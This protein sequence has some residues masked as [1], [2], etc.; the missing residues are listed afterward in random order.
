[1]AT[2][3]RRLILG[4]LSIALLISSIWL[5]SELSF[6]VKSNPPFYFNLI[7]AI[8]FSFNIA[9]LFAWF[10]FR[11]LGGI[12]VT[13]LS[14]LAVLW[15]DLRTGLYGYSLFTLS[16]FIAIFLGYASFRI[17]NRIDS[18]YTLKLEKLD[19]QSNVLSNKIAEQKRMIISLEEK[20]NR[21]STLKEI[22]ES[23]STQL[24]L[25]DVNK[26]IIEKAQK[27]L[28]E[29]GRVL[30]FLVDTDKQELMLSASQGASRVKTKKGDVFDHWVLRHRKSLITEDIVRDF[31]FP[32]DGVEESK[33]FF[34]S[35]IIVPLVSENKVIG[36]LRMDSLQEFMFA[37]DDLR[38]LDIIGHLG[39]VAIQNALLYS[40]TQELAIKDGL[41]G[42]VVRRYF[43]E[44]FQQEIKRAVRNKKT[45]SLLIF[46]IDYFKAYN[47]R[48]GHTAG[49]LVLK[50][51]ARTITSMMREGDIVGR[52]GGEEIVALLYGRDKTEAESEAEEIR[53]VIRNKPLTLRRHAANITV[54]IG[55]S[56]YPEDAVLEEELIKVADERLYKAKARGRDRVCSG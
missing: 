1:M 43:L 7:V 37:Q 39:A 14:F 22:A 40:R 33:N 6:G 55:L 29:A 45:L 44:R 28:G 38:L 8:I 16:F 46:D 26:L 24:S 56:S 23:L 54:S 32:A 49:D 48:Y 52:Y 36:I 18:S 42:L 19:E 4:A 47:D 27:T 25:N 34:R 2:P 12:L 17:K 53:K 50:H 51:L 15:L 11:M 9:V 21:Y 10:A 30:I 31:R 35:L 20:L 13:I 41:T 3:S 5:L